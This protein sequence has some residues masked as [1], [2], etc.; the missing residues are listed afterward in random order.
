NEITFRQF[1]LRNNLIKEVVEVQSAKNQDDVLLVWYEVSFTEDFEVKLETTTIKITDIVCQSPPPP[2]TLTNEELLDRLEE[3]YPPRN[4]I[5]EATLRM[6]R[7]LQGSA[8][9]D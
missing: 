8:N 5:R 2:K 7:G 4:V 3:P 1:L 9:S 6:F